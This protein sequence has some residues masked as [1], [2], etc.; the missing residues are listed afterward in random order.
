VRRALARA[1]AA[2]AAAFFVV[3]IL[4]GSPAADPPPG[5]PANLSVTMTNDPSSIVAQVGF[6]TYRVSVVNNG[7]DTG[8]DVTLTVALSEGLSVSFV[9]GCNTDAERRTVTCHFDTVAKGSPPAP[10]EIFV[11]ARDKLGS[12][13]VDADIK[14]STPDSDLDDN[15]ATLATTV[16]CGICVEHV[17]PQDT[18]FVNDFVFYSLKATNAYDRLARNVAIVDDLPPEVSFQSAFSSGPTGCTHDGNKVTCPLGDL[19]NGVSGTAFIL[20]KVKGPLGP[21]VDSARATGTITVDETDSTP[22]VSNESKST[23][24]V[25]PPSANLELKKSAPA[26]VALDDRLTYTLEVVNHGPDSTAETRVEDQLP[27]GTT[28][29]S[30]STSLGTCDGGATVVCLLGPLDSEDESEGGPSSA[31]VTIV[32]RPS[33]SGVLTNT[34]R[35]F[36]PTNLDL[37]GSVDPD[38]TN[39]SASVTTTP[40]C[41]DLSIAKSVDRETATIGDTVTY[42]VTVANAGPAAATGVTT[43]D[44]LPPE[45]SFAT[46][47]STQGTCTSG[48]VVDCA[49]GTLA[50]GGT[51]TITITARAETAGTVTNAATV[52]GGVFDPNG[53]NDTASV[54]HRIT[55]A[56]LSIEK[57]AA[58]D[59]VAL[60]SRITYTLTVRNHGP[61]EAT[62][63]RVTDALPSAVGFVSASSSAGTCSAGATVVCDLGTLASGGTATVT[64]VVEARTAGAVTNTATVTSPTHDGNPGDNT[65]S[66]TTRIV[67]AELSITKVDGPDPVDVGG[68][69]T[70]TLT[71]ANAGPSAAADVRVTDA[72]PGGVRFASA[73]PSQGTCSGAPQVVCSLGTLDAGASATVRIRVTARTARS[74]V[75]T[76]SVASTSFDPNTSNNSATTKTSVTSAD[77]S[78]TLAGAPDPVTVG[79]R[80]VYRIRVA[81]AGPTAAVGVVLTLDLPDGAAVVDR[82]SCTTGRLLTCKIGRLASGDEA[83]FTVAVTLD[84]SGTAAT[85]ARVTGTYVDPDGGNNVATARTNGRFLP[86]LVLR[87]TLGTPGSI[88][89]A[90]GT[91]FPPSTRVLL[92]WL[93][94]I[95]RVL[96]HTTARGRFRTPLL[97]FPNVGLGPRRLVAFAQ[98]SDPGRA[99]VPVRTRFL[100]VPGPLQPSSFVKR[101]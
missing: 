53:G 95:G 70:Y 62:G 51:A 78:V 59:P 57:V 83:R 47:T 30:A 49:L 18:A 85:T 61:S 21:I 34:A 13:D 69:L 94:G 64:V 63:V 93:P 88:T 38:S 22:I 87:P 28:F 43:H 76:A 101:R 45:V 89:F 37:G 56:N 52:A 24:E 96:V 1:C 58:P 79:D 77:L 65:A 90:V 26:T 29:V 15:H 31:T 92:G 91:G 39:N 12:F 6:T 20:A 66:A 40:L 14:S 60:G 75:N 7:P 41:D 42:T 27:A 84:R 17:D 72:L 16:T 74:V 81:N 50:V 35:A 80:L 3:T 11:Q 33:C 100:V 97:V 5:D 25:V 8:S 54:T 23:T 10:V 71:V 46:V 2:A 99:F 4:P 55:S 68:T 73:T 86:R 67:S 98:V 32:V 9:S 19:A 82:G 48:P 36:D 44:V